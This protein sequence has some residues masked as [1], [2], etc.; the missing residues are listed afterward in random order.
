MTLTRRSFLGAAGGAAVASGLG[1]AVA[2]PGAAEPGARPSGSSSG[3]DDRPRSPNGWVIDTASN[4]GGSV[5]L[6]PVAGAGFATALAIGAAGTILVHVLRRFNYE[7]T[8]LRDG[9]VTGFRPAAG[10]QS[11]AANHASGTA[12]DILPGMY[13]MGARGGFPAYQVAVIRD[14]LAECEGVI[15]WGGDYATPEECHFQMDLP[16]SAPE[17]AR[18]AERIR[19]RNQSAHTTSGV[20]PDVGDARRR[21][22]ADRL[23]NTQRAAGAVPRRV[24]TR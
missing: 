7:I 3:T 15:S 2:N 17:V 22:A 4:T 12:L 14:I 8:T 6:L 1:V 13:P 11:Y 24:P 5:W 10:L 21:V 9:D 23:A 20:V 19:G 18:L 16:P